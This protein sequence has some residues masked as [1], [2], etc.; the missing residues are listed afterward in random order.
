MG[1]W[2]QNLVPSFLKAF[3]SPMARPIFTP[4]TSTCSYN[5]VHKQQTNM[6]LC[7]GGAYYLPYSCLLISYKF[8]NGGERPQQGEHRRTSSFLH[9]LLHPPQY[10]PWNLPCGLL[11]IKPPV[12]LWFM[13]PSCIM[14]WMRVYLLLG[15]VG[16][17]WALEFESF[18]GPVNGIEPIGECHFGPKKLEICMHP[19]HYAWGC[20]NHRCINSYSIFT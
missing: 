4:S 17:C 16:G 11:C 14:F 19:K 9:Q 20:I 1:I 15:Q 10:G 12:H 5:R 18:L 3:V 13:Q 2:S 7:T 6:F 8:C